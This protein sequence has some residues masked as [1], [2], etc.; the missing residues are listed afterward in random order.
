[1]EAD[2]LSVLHKS[3]F[4][5]KLSAT[6]L[7]LQKLRS[8]TSIKSALQRF[9]SIL[10]RG[11]S[12]IDD[13]ANNSERKLGFQLW[14]DSQIQSVVSLGIAIVSS[15]RSLSEQAEPIVVAVVN[16]L[17]EFAVCYL[18]KSEFSGNDFSIQE[19]DFQ[20]TISASRGS[21]LVLALRA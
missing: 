7:F 2:D 10:K 21:Y 8:D 16:Q 15:S 17:V 20:H 5:D 9:Y 4:E 13:D 6:D 14:T 19:F 3:L 1:M 12:L 18:E 11:V